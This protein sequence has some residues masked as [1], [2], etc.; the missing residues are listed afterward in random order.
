M[1]AETKPHRA[2]VT[3][4]IEPSTPTRPPLSSRRVWGARLLAFA[5]DSLQWVMLPLF[6]VGFLSPAQDV[7]DVFIAAAM[8]ALVGW[9]WAFLPSFIAEVIPGVGLVPTWTLAVLFATRKRR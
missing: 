9:H 2:D 5:A 7:L 1:N 6:G 3:A 8:I 4:P